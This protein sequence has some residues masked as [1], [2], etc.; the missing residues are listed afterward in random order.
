MPTNNT[1][2]ANTLERQAIQRQRDAK[3]FA[4]YALICAYKSD[5]YQV[6]ATVQAGI[7]DINYVIDNGWNAG[8]TLLWLTA[9]AEQ[10]ELALTLIFRGADINAVA[11]AG[12]S[13]GK[14]VLDVAAECNNF[15]L[16][17]FLVVMGARTAH[18]EKILHSALRHN[19]FEWAAVELQKMTEIDLVQFKNLYETYAIDQNKASV[20]VNAFRTTTNLQ[21]IYYGA[22]SLGC[23][24]TCLALDALAE[25]PNYNNMRLICTD[26]NVQELNL[27]RNFVNKCET[28]TSLAD[29]NTKSASKNS[30]RDRE[31]EPNGRAPKRL[32]FG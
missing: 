30:Q 21:K 6:L 28:L 7:L 32:K 4:I 9:R 3:H 12:N 10:Y 31:E 27:L 29:I 2:L 11:L 18:F 16:A 23:K 20:F 13:R 19:E 5:W 22:K 26:L 15:A 25:N 8:R 24:L 17:K 1:Q 14:S